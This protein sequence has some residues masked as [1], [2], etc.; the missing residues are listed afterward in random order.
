[1]C[2]K[3]IHPN[4]LTIAYHFFLKRLNQ[5]QHCPN[6]FSKILPCCANVRGKNILGLICFYKQQSPKQMYGTNH[7][8]TAW[9]FLN[10]FPKQSTDISACTK[11]RAEG[12]IVVFNASQDV[13]CKKEERLR[14]INYG[15]SVMDAWLLVVEAFEVDWSQENDAVMLSSMVEMEW[16]GIEIVG[17]TVANPIVCHQSGFKSAMV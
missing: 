11:M 17:P 10:V 5:A 16:C 1:M 6:P 3:V 7:M 13:A 8:R 15:D 14:S 9:V 12:S 4:T 2:N